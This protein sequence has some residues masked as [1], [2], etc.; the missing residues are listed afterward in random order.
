MLTVLLLEDDALFRQSLTVTIASAGYSVC[1][2]ERSEDAVIQSQRIRPDVAIIDVML[3]SGPVSGRL[4]EELRCSNPGLRIFLITGYPDLQ[5]TLRRRYPGVETI[6]RKPFR[7][8]EVL[9][10]LE[11]IAGRSV[12]H[13]SEE[14]SND[15]PDSGAENLCGG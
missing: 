10:L 13:S 3:G 14:E 7:R 6:L 8:R 11:R 1:A 4:L 5:E 12:A 9:E 15:R 2:V